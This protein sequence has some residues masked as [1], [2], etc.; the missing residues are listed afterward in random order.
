MFEEAER[1]RQMKFE[2]N[3]RSV[4]DVIRYAERRQRIKEIWFG[5]IWRK[6]VG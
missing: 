4:L 5:V 6:G 2:D 3:E 1:E